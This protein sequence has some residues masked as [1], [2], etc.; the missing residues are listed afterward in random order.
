MTLT[1]KRLLATLEKLPQ[2]DRYVVAYSGGK[3]SHVLLHLLAGLFG[4]SSGPRLSAVHINHGLQPNAGSWAAHCAELCRQLDV[5]CQTLELNLSPAKGES[6]EAQAR[7][8][9][10]RALEKLI[11]TGDL[12]LTAH[13]QDDQAETVLLQLLR[14]AG[15]AGLSAMPELT[16]FGCG[17]MARPLLAVSAAEIDDYAKAEQLCWIEDPSNRSLQFDRN[18]LRNQVIPVL[19]GRWP[20]LGRTL[21]RSARHCAETQ[22]LVE[23]AVADDLE[24][25]WERDNHSL[26]VTGIAVLPPPRARAL[27]RVWI[28]AEGFP[29]PGSA[30][31][32][33]VLNEMVTAGR[34]RNPLVH[35]PGAEVRRFRDRIYI[36]RPLPRLTHIAPLEWDGSTSVRLPGSLGRL[37]AYT[38]PGGLSLS[39]WRTARIRIKFSARQ[40]DGVRIAGQLHSTTFKNLFQQHAVPVWMRPRIP[41][42]YLDNE[43]AAVGDLCICNPFAVAQ[44]E[45]GVHLRWIR[46]LDTD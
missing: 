10:Y 34:D 14:G 18:F 12:L 26:A 36:M 43:L 28:S 30:R 23:A 29:V 20:A 32:E 46:V 13:H 4:K 21:S 40:Q 35:W 27:L 8:A 17:Y 45:R 19:R 5:P 39:D 1:P 42:I 33:R 2:T 25:F 38:G 22:A 41:L 11:Q 31:L 7:M 24:A 16:R 37:E 15:P 6:I 44:S 9:R 3:D